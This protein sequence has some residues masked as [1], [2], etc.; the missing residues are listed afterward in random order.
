MAIT[1]N[2]T[3][4]QVYG[5]PDAIVL[6][7]TSTGTDGAVVGRR[8]YLTDSNGEPVV[9]DGNSN[10]YESWPDF[11]S[12][13]TIT[14]DVLLKDM[15]LY[16]RVDWLDSGNSVLYTKT[17][18]VLFPLYL[19]TYFINL[20]KAQSSNEKLRDSANFYANEIKL[21][22]SIQEAIT[23]V[24]DIEDIRSAQAALDRG[25]KLID[26]PQNFF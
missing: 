25:K 23:A 16:V 11:P 7:D 12:T 15:A 1:Q 6:T 3:A 14:L 26:N 20:I 2:F 5:Q 21:L 19:K 9:E 18:L 17:S 8:V 13:T 22:C 4:S 24:T 10:D